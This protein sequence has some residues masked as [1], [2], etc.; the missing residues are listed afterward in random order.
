M[1]PSERFARLWLLVLGT[2]IGLVT[3]EL[4]ARIAYVPP[5]HERLL[6]AQLAVTPNDSIVHNSWGLRG[7]A[8]NTPKSPGTSRVLLLG[9]SF[10]FGAG[11]ADDAAVFPAILEQ[12]LNASHSQAD[13]RVEIL[14]GGIPGSRTAAW[15]TL[16]NGVKDAFEPDVIVAVFFLRDGTLT[17]SIGGFFGPIRDEITERNRTSRLYQQSY[18]YRLFRDGRDRN[19]IATRY[20]QAINE[21]YLGNSSQ[22]EEWSVARA[23][24]LEIQRIGSSLGAK[25]GLVV[26]PILVDLGDTYPF[27]AVCDLLV[28]FGNAN[29]FLTFDLLP[30]FRGHEASALW[31][32]P[33]DQHPNEVG[34]LIAADA[35]MPHFESLVGS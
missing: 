8:Y 27:Q 3:A 28:Q 29:D 6:D 22:T 17:S 4:I 1:A 32:A 11:V 18:V 7:P 21:S 9:D 26:F 35:L 19:L 13:T 23:N 12:R 20:A 10:T 30:A 15:V 16:L 33:Q 5:W 25:V 24:L 2:G 34:H 31:V 14:N